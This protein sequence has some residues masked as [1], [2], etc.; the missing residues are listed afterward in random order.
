MTAFAAMREPH[1][2]TLPD[3]GFATNSPQAETG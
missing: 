2:G 1:A 3:D